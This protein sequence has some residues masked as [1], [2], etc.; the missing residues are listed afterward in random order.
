[1]D[2]ERERCAQ[3]GMDDYLTKPYRHVELTTMLRKWTTH[4][5]R[6]ITPRSAPASVAVAPSP[7][8]PIRLQS[9]VLD[10]MR[11]FPGGERIL[12]SALAMYRQTSPDRIAALIAAHAQTDRA[13]LERIAHSLK[14]SS[15]MVGGVYLAKLLAELESTAQTADTHRLDQAVRQIA[16]EFQQLLGLLPVVTN[17]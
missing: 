13:A 5:S 14:S 17:V 2:G 11:E 7:A 4:R 15:A 8:A 3:A 9:R 1:M 12:S 16:D 6:V 10:E